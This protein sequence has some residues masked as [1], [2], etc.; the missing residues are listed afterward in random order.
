MDK[1]A[2]TIAE[3]VKATGLSRTRLY[4]EIKA[5]RLRVAKIGRRTLVP[6]DEIR[7]WL[8]RATQ[9]Q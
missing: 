8:A 6:P 9:P 1:V 3:T 2:L 4:E 5:G 7:A